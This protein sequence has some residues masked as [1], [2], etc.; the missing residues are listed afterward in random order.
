ML[1]VC[2]NGHFLKVY[3]NLFTFHVHFSGGIPLARNDSYWIR[4]FMMKKAP[5]LC[6]KHFNYTAGLTVGTIWAELSDG[7]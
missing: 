5:D 1:M 4:P 6:R 2:H 3:L 7:Q